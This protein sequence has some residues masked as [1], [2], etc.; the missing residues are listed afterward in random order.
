MERALSDMS[1]EELWELFPISLVEPKESWAQQYRKIEA[2]LENLLP[3]VAG[4]RVSHIG[5][6]AIPGILAKDIVD[7]LVEVD[8]SEDIASVASVLERNGFIRMSATAT[9]ISLNRGYTPRGFADEVYHV[10][11]RYAG[12]DDEVHFRDYLN[13]HPEVAA[14]YQRLKLALWRQY[15]HDRDA[16]TEGKAD[17]VR[18]CT[19]EARRASC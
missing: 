9:R 3:D 13:D 2:L 1:L 5:S 6:T 11:V 14:E 8:A 17:F 15:E 19:A 16:Y 4:L 18:R 7:V 12:D 10:H